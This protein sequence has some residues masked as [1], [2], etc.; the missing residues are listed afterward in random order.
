MTAK[1]LLTELHQHHPLCHERGHI[2][3][4][5][6]A[7]L[8]MDPE[9]CALHPYTPLMSGQKSGN[10]TTHLITVP[11]ASKRSSHQMRHE[12]LH[13]PVSGYFGNYCSNSTF[14][15]SMKIL[16]ITPHCKLN[17]PRPYGEK[18]GIPYQQC[19]KRHS[20]PPNTTFS[21]RDTSWKI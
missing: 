15:R 18:T 14:L 21:T 2:W 3:R 9:C 17:Q 5:R 8:C 12:S 16:S 20:V 19:K 13:L 4:A 10:P 1:S 11:R 7:L 6:W